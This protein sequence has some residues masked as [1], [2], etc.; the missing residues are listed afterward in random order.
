VILANIKAVVAFQESSFPR[1]Q[2]SKGSIR[3]FPTK[4]DEA[5]QKKRFKA[6]QKGSLGEFSGKLDH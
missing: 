2:L 3:S 6:F 1:K 5:F 4:R